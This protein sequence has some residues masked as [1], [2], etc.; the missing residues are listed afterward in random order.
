MFKN[1]N[2]RSKHNVPDGT[3]NFTDKSTK[4]FKIKNK[5]SEIGNLKSFPYSYHI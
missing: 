5:K 4:Y 2:G 1:N 3:F